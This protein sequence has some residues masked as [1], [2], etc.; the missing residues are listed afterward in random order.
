VRVVLL[1]VPTFVF[2][3]VAVVASAW[4]MGDERGESQEAVSRNRAATLVA[5]IAAVLCA[6]SLL[7]AAALFV[8]HAMS[9]GNMD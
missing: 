4:A 7:V 8:V 2:A 3:L 6:L 5:V 9:A 1:F